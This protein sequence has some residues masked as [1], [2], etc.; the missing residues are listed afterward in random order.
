MRVVIVP[1]GG[2]GRSPPIVLAACQV[3]VENDD[4]TVLAIAAEYGPDDAVKLAHAGDE[5]F[6]RTL[7]ELGYTKFTVCDRIQL[8]PAPPGARLVAGPRG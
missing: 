4:G 1:A 8:P 3:V 6:N 7:A 2:I 5:D